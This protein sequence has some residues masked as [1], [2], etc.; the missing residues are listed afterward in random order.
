MEA[1][2]NKLQLPST[3]DIT[4]AAKTV[5]VRALL[6]NVSAQG[7]SKFADDELSVHATLKTK[8]LISLAGMKG[9][10]AKD[11]MYKMRIHCG[12]GEF[13]I[14]AGK[15][16]TGRRLPPYLQRHG[17]PECHC[18]DALRWWLPTCLRYLDDGEA[19]L[20]MGDDTLVIFEQQI[21]Y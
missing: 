20:Y 3:D 17:W 2:G 5:V 10:L 16:A 1:G 12:E 7:W 18:A 15:A 19:R 11:S 4:S 21:L 6:G 8:D 13:G 14:V 9:L